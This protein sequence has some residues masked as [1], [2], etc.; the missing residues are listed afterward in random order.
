MLLIAVALFFGALFFSLLFTRKVRNHAVCN[1]WS[2]GPVQQHHLHTAPIPR[3]GGVA[4]YGTFVSL[5][6]LLLLASRLFRFSLGFSPRTVLWVLVPA[7]LVFLIGVVD[8]IWSV[9]PRTKFAAQIVAALILFL[10]DF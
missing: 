6:L 4:V 5:T 2:V 3:F 1:R 10:G 9:S 7:T 8:D